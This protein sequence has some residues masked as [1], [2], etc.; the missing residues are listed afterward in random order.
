MK[1]VGFSNKDMGV[2]FVLSLTELK[3]HFHKHGGIMKTAEL[4]TL[5]LSSRQ[6]LQLV[7]KGVLDKIS[8]GKYQLSDQILPE[9]VLITKLFSSAVLYLESA[10]VQYG[11]TDRIPSKWQLA[12][13]KNT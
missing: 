6:L 7:H 12:V 13:D 9:E 8:R 3:H 1:K 10:L 2:H 11:Y 5:G 4:R